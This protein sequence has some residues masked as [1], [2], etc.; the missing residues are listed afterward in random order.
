[1]RF[2]PRLHGSL[3]R[4]TLFPVWC[5]LL[6]Y[7]SPEAETVAVLVLELLRVH[8]R[9]LHGIEYIEPYFEQMVKVWVWFLYGN[10]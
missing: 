6:I 7:G 8:A 5:L 10:F 9:R 2:Q 3:I 4:H 1:M